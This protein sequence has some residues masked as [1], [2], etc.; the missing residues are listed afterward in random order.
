M[1]EMTLHQP[2]MLDEVITTLAPKADG[3]YI[4]ATF[5][6]GG[7]SRAILEA[8]P[9]HVMAIDQDPDAIAR[10]QSLVASYSPHFSLAHGRFSNVKDLYH[11]TYQIGDDAAPSLDGIVFDLGVCSTQLD[12][13]ERGFSFQKDGP[14][15]MRM[16]QSGL[17]AEE[18]VN[19][20]SES[21]LADILYRYGDERASRRIARAIVKARGEAPITRTLQLAEIIHSVMPRPKPGQSDSATRSFQALRIYVNQEMA[22]IEQALDAAQALLKPDG[23]LVVVT[24]HSLEDRLVKH[25]IATRSGKIAKP[26]RHLPETDIPPVFFEA[27]TRKPLLPSDQETT[28][29]PRARSAKLRAAR[30]INH[31]PHTNAYGTAKKEMMI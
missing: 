24:F 14:L 27:V 2:V 5:G 31:I 15:D 30:R 23:L 29:N 25:F 6:N 26:S 4:D 11:A 13:A 7:Y 3:R 18:V 9:C 20:L 21:D 17:D 19:S 28:T 1:A 10:G 8:A 12:Q 22:E 16:S